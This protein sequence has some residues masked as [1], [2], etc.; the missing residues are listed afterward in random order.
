MARWTSSTA[1]RNSLP[2]QIVGECERGIPLDRMPETHRALRHPFVAGVHITDLQ[3]EAKLAAHTED[4]SAYGCFIETI[5]PLAADTRIKMQIT[6]NGQH[7]VADG[8]VAYSRPKAGM[9]VV[10]V[11]FEPGSLAILN[12]WLDDLRT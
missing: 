12:K 7:M 3:T 11:S 10:F 6:R 4:I 1:S 8:K 9:G 5:E 2:L